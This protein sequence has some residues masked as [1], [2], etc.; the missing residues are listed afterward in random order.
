[1]S[2]APSLFSSDETHCA[3]LGE[4]EKHLLHSWPI[5]LVRLAGLYT[6]AVPRYLQDT[7]E[8]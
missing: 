7:G 1:M 6:A 2:I 3:E 4:A 8:K 5:S